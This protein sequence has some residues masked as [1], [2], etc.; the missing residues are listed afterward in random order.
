MGTEQSSL[1]EPK[2]PD[3]QPVRSAMSR[4]RSVRSNAN[5]LEKSQ[6]DGRYLPS[7]HRPKNSL[8][9]PAVAYTM[10][11][12]VEPFSSGTNTGGYDSPQWGWYT[13]L[14]PPSPEMYYSRPT[15][16]LKAG[17]TSDTSE[18]SSAAEVFIAP[19][20]HS[21]PNPVFQGLQDK[22]KAAPMGWPSVPL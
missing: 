6:M 14:T 16:S 9:K 10:H 3:E 21:L 1:H 18:A 12:G 8:L 4:S 15:K 13:N 20:G 22:H 2:P 11:H 19:T 7:N 5:S 17:S